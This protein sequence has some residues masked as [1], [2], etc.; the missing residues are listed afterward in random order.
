MRLHN[1]VESRANDTHG[2]CAGLLQIGQVPER[3]GLSLR[4]VVVDGQP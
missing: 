2:T 4:T 3:T 1:T